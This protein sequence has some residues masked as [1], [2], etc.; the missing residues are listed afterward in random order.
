MQSAVSACDE[1]RA[2]RGLVCNCVPVDNTGK[3]VLKVPDFVVKK[4]EEK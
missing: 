4:Y 1:V 2:K 3:A